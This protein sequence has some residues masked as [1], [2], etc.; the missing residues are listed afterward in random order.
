MKVLKAINNNVVSCVDDD[1]KEL[2]VMGRGLGFHAKPGDLMDPAKAEKIFRMDSP[3][4]ITRLKE[5][6]ARLPE[7]L[8]ELSSSIIDYADQMLGRRL[9][10]SAYLTLTDHIQ[11]AIERSRLGLDLHNALDTEVK[12]FYPEEFAVGQHSLNLIRQELGVDLPQDEAAS[13]ALHIVNAE[14]TGSMNTTMRVAHVLQPML[15][16]IE[17]WPGIQL[18]KNHLFYDELIVHLKFLAMQAFSCEEKKYADNSLAD[19]VKRSIPVAF[20]CAHAVATC[21]SKQGGRAV[22]AVEQAYLAICI[23]RSSIS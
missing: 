19:A 3:E 15:S 23:C 16:I 11:F 22:S 6:M 13:I 20:A 21:L 14:Y 1:G 4:N 7:N 10:E 8:L 5:L 9:N 12:V 2:V 17:S 18:D